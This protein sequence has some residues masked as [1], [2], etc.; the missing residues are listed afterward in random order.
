[1]ARLGVQGQTPYPLTHDPYPYD[2]SLIP[3]YC[4]QEIL[5]GVLVI[6]IVSQAKEKSTPSPRPRNG[7][8]Q[9]FTQMD[10]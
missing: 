2:L 6:V 7:V 1:M 10:T 8:G 9:K 4:F 3:Q 5:V